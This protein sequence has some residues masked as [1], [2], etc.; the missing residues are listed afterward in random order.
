VEKKTAFSRHNLWLSCRRMQIDLFLSHYTKLKSKCIKE[1]H[2]KSETLKIIEEKVGKSLKVMG[3]EGKFLN[4]TAMSC[5]VRL[6][7]RARGTSP[8]E[9]NN[10]HKGPHRIPHRI[11][12]TLVSGTQRLPQCNH[13]EPETGVHREA[14]YL[15][16]T[17]GTSPFHSTQ[18]P[19]YLKS[20]V[21]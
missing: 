7:I 9:S 4:R 17:W 10:T 15:V 13:T 12:R 16:L 19:G 6:R 8:V 11:L 21:I 5:S 2:I 3:T 14:E 1:F 18:D 20:G